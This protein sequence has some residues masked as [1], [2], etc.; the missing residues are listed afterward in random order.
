[1]GIYFIAGLTVRSHESQH[2]LLVPFPPPAPSSYPIGESEGLVSDKALLFSSSISRFHQSSPK[3]Y[4]KC[5][6]RS[7][8]VRS[9]SE[10]A[11]DQG[12]GRS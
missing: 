6:L 7:I 2:F 11:E 1:M 9:L 8:A 10:E 5:Y 3:N 4:V 12:G